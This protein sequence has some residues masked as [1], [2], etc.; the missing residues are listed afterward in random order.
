[1]NEKYN[2]EPL[3]SEYFETKTEKVRHQL[4]ISYVGLVKYVV[5]NMSMPTNKIL[6]TNDYLNIGIIGLCEAIERFDSS[7][8]VKF[9]TYAVPRIRGKIQDELRRLDWLSRTA[10]KKVNELVQA[11]DKIRSEKKRDVHYDDI[12]EEMDITPKQLQ[13]YLDAALAAK[14]A[15]TLNESTAMRAASFDDDSYDPLLELPDESYINKLV[16]MQ[17]TER[18]DHITSY[19]NNQKK[20]NKRLVITLYY[21]EELTFKEIGQVLNL[22]ESRVC[23]IHSQMLSELRTSVREFENA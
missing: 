22:S 12:I 21:Y 6:E 8:G 10:R 4:I 23:Q 9:E 18:I 7:R 5:Y 19:L 2:N 20:P 14:A 17:N 1:M 3:W 11:T 13:S 15:L 16:E